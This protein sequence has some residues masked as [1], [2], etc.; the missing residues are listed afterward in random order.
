MKRRIRVRRRRSPIIE[1]ELED[2][3]EMMETAEIV[4]ADKEFIESI[5]EAVEEEL[6]SWGIVEDEFKVDI[7]EQ[8]DIWWTVIP[9]K[10]R[11]V[12]QGG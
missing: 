2:L 6:R 9:S 8:G 4:R 7:E 11:E 1:A 3:E 5:R 12:K 10:P